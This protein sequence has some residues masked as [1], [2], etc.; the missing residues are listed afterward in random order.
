[1]KK[2]NLTGH[3]KSGLELIIERVKVYWE[4]P[5]DS[6]FTQHNWNHSDR[7]VE[8]IN[9]LLSTSNIVLEKEERFV[10][11]AAIYLHDIGMQLPEYAQLP[12]KT[13]YTSGDLEEIR[14]NHHESSYAAIID[15]IKGRKINL[16]LN[17][18]LDFVSAIAEV[19]RYHRKLDL[20]NLSDKKIGKTNLRL[21]LL[22]AILRFGDEL[23]ADYRRVSIDILKTRD[24][25]IISKF[26]WW[27]HHY[28]QSI[29]IVDNTITIN[30]RFPQEYQTE[31][32]LINLF[33]HKI[34]DSIY[35]QRTELNDIFSA[36]N[37][38]LNANIKI[39]R[40]TFEPC[41]VEC[42]PNELYDF[43]KRNDMNIEKINSQF[44]LAK[45]PV[46]P[47][48]V[49]N[50]TNTTDMTF[51]IS[52]MLEFMVVEDYKNAISF[53][54]K[55]GMIR[56][57]GASTKDQLALAILSANCYFSV[58]KLKVA[59]YYYNKILELSAIQPFQEFYKELA[60]SYEVAAL[61]NLGLVYY[62][63][64]ENETALTF[65][66]R[67][68][69]MHIRNN[70]L[71]GQARQLGNIGSVYCEMRDF[72][73][74][75]E[76]FKSALQINKMLKNNYGIIADLCGLGS[77]YT[78]I[79]DMVNAEYYYGQAFEI[80]NGQSIV[81]EA[82]LLLNTGA[83]LLDINPPSALEK[84]LKA[85]ELFES[86]G[87][88]NGKANAYINAGLA[89]HRLQ[90]TQSLDYFKLAQKAFM[91][92]NNTNREKVCLKVII[93]FLTVDDKY[94]EIQKYQKRL[95]DIEQ[96]DDR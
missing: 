95:Q 43:I 70:S 37:I 5:L 40:T 75:I 20:N 14:K 24:I 17:N 27:G 36:N 96:I 92:L 46:I 73:K 74:A 52:K 22:A 80:N 19:A 58:G 94:N 7:I 56:S 63:Q 31:Q 26:Y 84:F 57:F 38:N 55:E 16:G 33:R 30:Y 3:F 86:I 91:D 65:Y 89:Y 79:G 50:F 10:L 8:H 90:N 81:V 32:K 9:S 35:R 45:S 28:V 62:H 12:K 21:P 51:M 11:L 66:E 83:I 44:Q 61:G 4:T 77:V 15:S 49:L 29:S 72:P 25:P 6:W 42:I 47:T 93:D 59:E 64:G 68:R 71:D 85:L 48:D 34:W 76:K 41:G 69:D 67:A 87:Y 39:G 18:Y 78:R 23:D 82:T 13:T 53:T 1:V 88:L 54:E 2:L 60:Y